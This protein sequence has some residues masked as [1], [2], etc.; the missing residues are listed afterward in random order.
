[1]GGFL[2]QWRIPIAVLFS[3]CLVGASYVLARAVSS[4]PS[5]EASPETAL[6]QTVAQMDSDKD[7]LP[8]W[9]ETLY[10]TD[11]QVADT[12]NLGMADGDAVR[13][14]LIVPKAISDIEIAA[15][16]IPTNSKI[17]YEAEDLP[18]PTPGTLTDS[19]AKQFLNR[20][21]TAKAKNNGNDLTVTQI[22]ALADA[23][24]AELTNA[25]SRA[26]DYRNRWGMNVSGA[27]PDAIRS[28][29]AAAEAVTKH[30]PSGAQKSDT[31]YFSDVIE[32]RDVSA[33]GQLQALSKSYRNIAVG[34]A[35]LATP[36]ELVTPSLG[37]V[38]GVMRL[39]TIYGDIARA[40]DDPF[41]ALLALEQYYATQRAVTR[42]FKELASVYAAENVVLQKG[43]PG[44]EY[45][46]LMKN[47]E[48]SPEKYL[49]PW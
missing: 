17:D 37:I 48:S 30:N 49:Q 45:V 28:Y 34:L 12:R 7:G 1:M 29:A 21:V 6:L 44:A 13:S 20:Y 41:T 47:I 38:N 32:R 2:Q 39:S 27:G 9:E 46:N 22:N 18:I 25:V 26:A 16:T 4:P 35:A 11:P 42:S 23:M 31:Q 3:L 5:A 24:I 36:E 33:A 40:S 43:T 8:D 10:G 14:G 15:A 19:F